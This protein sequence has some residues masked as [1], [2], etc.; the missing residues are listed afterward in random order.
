MLDVSSKNLLQAVFQTLAYADVFDYPLTAP[1]VHRYLPSQ[2]T[3]LEEVELALAAKTVFSKHGEYFTLRG[4]EEIAKTRIQ[5]SAIAARLWPKAARYG[6]VIA[7]LPFVRMVAVTGSLAMSNPDEGH[8]VDYMIITAPNRLW[9]CRAFSLLITRVAKLEG[10][11]L[12]PNYLVTTNALALQEHSLY[13]A[14][15][16]AQMIPISGMETYTQLCQQN[17][18]I[19]EY[20]PNAALPPEYPNAVKQM[21]RP[22]VLQRILE[23]ILRLPFGDWFE[24]WEMDRKIKRLSR[25]Q[26]SSFESYFSA[27]VCKGHVDR[28]GENIVSAL[29]VR[30]QKTT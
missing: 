7:M 16:V 2:R 18:W 22:S 11:S 6:R 17:D 4:R 14:H 10:V 27:D 28:H 5:R 3:S 15:E 12:C 24:R 21:R 20:L 26:S 29:A 23:I 13:V 25:E 19:Q 8:D 9:T 30:L 1:E